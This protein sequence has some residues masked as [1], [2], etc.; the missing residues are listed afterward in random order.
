MILSMTVMPV[1][2]VNLLKGLAIAGRL[3]KRAFG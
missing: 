1:A 3:P 2:F